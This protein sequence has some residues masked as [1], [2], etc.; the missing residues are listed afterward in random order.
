M[1]GLLHFSKKNNIKTAICAIGNNKVRSEK[2][3]FLKNEGFEM[4]SLVH[5]KSLID[6]NAL[7]FSPGSQPIKLTTALP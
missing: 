7:T 2:Y 3:N 6:T 4:V 5:P 1:E